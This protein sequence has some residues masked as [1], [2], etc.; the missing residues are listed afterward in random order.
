V[1]LLGRLFVNHSP[2]GPADVGSLPVSGGQFDYRGGWI[3]ICCSLAAPVICILNWQIA[4]R[5]LLPFSK[6]SLRSPEKPFTDEI[7]DH[8]MTGLGVLDGMGVLVIIFLLLPLFL[9][10]VLARSA[11]EQVAGFLRRHWR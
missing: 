5:W 11:W 3:G 1:W 4:C 9:P 6:L 8:R 10:I 7:L 2:F